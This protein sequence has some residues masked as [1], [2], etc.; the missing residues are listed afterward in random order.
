MEQEWSIADNTC[1]GS[2]ELRTALLMFRYS[3]SDDQKKTCKDGQYVPLPAPLFCLFHLLL[4]LF[5]CRQ[6]F[7]PPVP[8]LL[9]LCGQGMQ[10]C[11][12]VYALSAHNF[13]NLLPL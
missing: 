8:P 9:V 6:S 5:S 10:V 2:A 13:G 3:R 1:W 4:S 11:S 7:L 12:T